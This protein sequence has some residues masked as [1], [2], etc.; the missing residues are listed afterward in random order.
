[1]AAILSSLPLVTVTDDRATRALAVL[2]RQTQHM[3]RSINDLL[4][5]TRVRHGKLRLERS[6]TEINEAMVSAIETVRSHAESKELRLHGEPAPEPMFVD[7]D[8]ERLAQILDNLLRNALAYTDRGE[9]VA[10]VRRENS[11]ARVA[12]RDTGVGIRPQDIRGLFEAYRRG[13]GKRTEGLGLGLALVKALVEAGW[14]HRLP[15]RGTRRGQRVQL[16]D[17]AGGSGSGNIGIRPQQP[18]TRRRIL[19]VDDQ[20]DVAAMFATLLE[21]LGQ[22]V[23]VAYDASTAITLAREHRPEVAFLDVTMPGVS[24][25]ELARRLRQEFAADELTLIAVTGHDRSDA[26]VQEGAFDRHLLKPV[27]VDSLVT[28]LNTAADNTPS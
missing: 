1:M 16:Y 20:R 28:V 13:D 26:R 2:Q 10:H 18:S 24:G 7:A 11:V 23:T 9:V 25:A 5:V 21:S 17:S 8:P 15:E 22:D 14:N 3:T 27:T 19:V 4:D 6:P 12:I